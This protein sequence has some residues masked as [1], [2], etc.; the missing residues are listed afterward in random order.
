[1]TKEAVS[2]QKSCQ[3][4]DVVE[5]L[6]HVAHAFNCNQN[7]EYPWVLGLK[8]NPHFAVNPITG[9]Q[10]MIEDIVELDEGHLQRSI[11][12]SIYNSPNPREEIKK[13]VP[14]RPKKPWK[15]TVVNVNKDGTL[16][17][18]IDSNMGSGMVTLQY[19]RV[20]IDGTGRI[21]HTC[22]KPRPVSS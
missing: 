14:L 20:P 13:L 12:P 6:P 4:G 8:Q 16:D 9:E 7:N 19:K 15:A 21:P 18:D 10:E 11:L 2:E 5:Y 3:V 22:R 17:L 1:M